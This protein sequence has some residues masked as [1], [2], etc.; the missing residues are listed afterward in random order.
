MKLFS[1]PIAVTALCAGAG[2]IGLCLR[3]WLLSAAVDSKG[4]LTSHPAV[5]LCWLP[6]AVVAVVLILCAAS[7]SRC[8]LVPMPLRAVGAAF[9]ALGLTVMGVQFATRMQG[10]PDIALCVLAIAG[11]IC[12]TAEAWL[13]A[14]RQR[15]PSF[16]YFPSI[17]FFIVFLLLR[18]RQ[19]SC[20]P[21]LHLYFFQLTAAVGLMFSLYHK[22]LLSE[23][24][25]RCTRY[26]VFSR[27]ALFFCIC[28]IAG[29]SDSIF[30]GTMAVSLI[31]DGCTASVTSAPK[32]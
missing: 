1:K 24:D 15:I 26:L 2:L 32:E 30:Y 7:R 14:R 17:L 6:V 18:Y 16:L 19:W 4:M 28:A 31:F 13:I 21:E 25:A 9:S 11:A 29:G 12:S 10:P 23:G 5:Y 27:G 22:A 3:Q 20:E 8:T